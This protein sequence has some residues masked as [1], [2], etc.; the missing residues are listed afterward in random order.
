MN[1]EI[2]VSDLEILFRR[3]IEKFKK[4][5]ISKFIFEYDEYWI[6]LTDEWNKL[7]E[8]PKAAVGS[9]SDDV[10]FIKSV[11]NEEEMISYLELERLA[12]ILRA[13]SENLLNR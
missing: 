4:D 3:L 5:N 11:I 13:S 8:V 9:L 1:S 12:S 10:K 7:E 2:S 6:I